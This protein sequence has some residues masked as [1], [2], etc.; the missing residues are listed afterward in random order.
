MSFVLALIGLGIAVALMVSNAHND[1]VA[2]PVF[3]FSSVHVLYVF[4]KVIAIAVSDTYTAEYYQNNGVDVIVSYMA[5]LC[6]LATIL[7]YKFLAPKQSTAYGIAN[8]KVFTKRMSL[9]AVVVGGFGLGAFLGLVAMNGGLGNYYMELS[10]YQMELTGVS[11]W[12]IFLSR[13]IY[14]AIAA[15][16]LVAA[17]NLSRFSLLLLALLSVFPLMNVLFLFRRS[18]LLFLAFIV[19]YAVAATGRIPIK[20]TFVLAGICLMGLAITLFPYLR[21]EGISAVT[22]HSYGIEDL[23]LQERIVASFAVDEG[24][25]IARAAS[26][27]ENTLKSG[28][29]GFGAF[30][31]N[32]LVDQFVPATLIGADAKSSFYL[33]QDDPTNQPQ[34]YFD[35]A[36]YFYVAPMGFAQAYQQFGAFG[37]II[38][39]A[40]GALIA[41]VERKSSKVSNRIFSMVA[42]P[43][44]CLAASNDITSIPA[45]LVT[46]WIL[47]R[48]LGKTGFEVFLSKARKAYRL[49]KIFAPNTAWRLR[50]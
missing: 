21:Q 10:F 17:L 23:S 38:F 1:R 22:G 7:T 24:D 18:D 43:I 31:W 12:L 25:E 49:P 47:T 50:R 48:F 33:G 28:N 20:R 11:V 32:S 29:Y 46:F 6:F 13:F 2:S 40:L 19:I 44:I 8:V 16:A 30:I 42:L 45:R 4:P 39:A 3:L 9:F 5:L 14:P 36:T 41:L 27:I 15:T 35:E 34:G 37:W 26:T